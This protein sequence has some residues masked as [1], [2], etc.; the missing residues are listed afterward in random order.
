MKINIINKLTIVVA[1]II[2]V[3]LCSI[4]FYLNTIYQQ[5]ALRQVTTTLHQNFNVARL[6]LEDTLVDHAI[7]IQD[8]DTIADKLAQELNFRVTIV[9]LE[10]VVL[11]DSEL[12][13]EEIS[14]VENH[15]FRPEIQDAKKNKFGQS[16]RF[17]TTIQK[18]F[19]YMATLFGQ[20][21]PIGFIRFA[22]PMPLLN[23]M[24]NRLKNLVIVSL[25]MAV[26]WVI[27]FVFWRFQRYLAS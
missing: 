25:F 4:Y 13:R 19:L 23:A 21:K 16:Q 7:Q 20:P 3:V 11:G 9:D 22:M 10:G 2:A 5:D 8:I 17:S 26:W 18:D 24:S 6:Y 15:L 12:T 14:G 1:I 27:R